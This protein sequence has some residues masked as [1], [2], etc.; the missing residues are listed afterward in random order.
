MVYDE[1]MR[2]CRIVRRRLAQSC[3][4]CKHEFASE[5]L[6]K[7]DG[8]CEHCH[9]N[10][11]EQKVDESPDKEE[12]RLAVFHEKFV[13]GQANS[14]LKPGPSELP[15]Y[16]DEV[17]ARYGLS[18]AVAKECYEEG[19]ARVWHI[20]QCDKCDGVWH[21]PL[22]GCTDTFHKPTGKLT[23]AIVRQQTMSQRPSLLEPM[24]TLR[25]NGKFCQKCWD[26]PNK[27]FPRVH[28]RTKDDK[29]RFYCPNCGSMVMKHGLNG[30]RE[31]VNGKWTGGYIGVK[32]SQKEKTK[33]LE[34]A[35]L[36]NQMVQV[37]KHLFGASR[38]RDME[39]LVRAKAC[40]GQ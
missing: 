5:E 9:S 35:T 7:Y 14:K 28:V 12:M 20:P 24:N 23:S 16:L 37:S 39:R 3:N 10:R 33:N 34:N 11:T 31:I 18:K 6:K 40:Y 4:K 29:K 38:S 8:K 32:T 22:N 30:W 26:D 36:F 25:A 19:S 17:H 2:C 1:D 21:T 27:K 13:R 15:D